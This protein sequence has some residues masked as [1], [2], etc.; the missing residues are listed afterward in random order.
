MILAIP[1]QGL[2]AQSILELNVETTAPVCNCMGESQSSELFLTKQLVM[3]SKHLL[4]ALCAEIISFSPQQSE[5]F[6]TMLCT[7]E[8]QQF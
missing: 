3:S 8:F 2:T 7:F 4:M 1:Y 5:H 6:K